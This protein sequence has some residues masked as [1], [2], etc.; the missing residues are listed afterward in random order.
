LLCS[1][2][3]HDLWKITL[4]QLLGLATVSLLQR[5]T[6]MCSRGSG[7]AAGAKAA[8]RAAGLAW[9]GIILAKGNLTVR[10][11]NSGK[12]TRGML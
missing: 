7:Q 1:R 11:G 12:A 2:R 6:V 5:G 4:S 10:R 3:V 8:E 9:V